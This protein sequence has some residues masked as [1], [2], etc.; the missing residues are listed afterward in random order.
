MTRVF[1][2]LATLR[3]QLLA[4]LMTVV[5]V[6]AYEILP[7]RKL[8]FAPD[9]VFERILASDG[10]IGGNSR[11]IWVNKDKDHL[12]CNLQPGYVY[13]YCG[14]HFAFDTLAHSGID[15][16]PYTQLNTH[17][18]YEGK[19]KELRVYLRNRDPSSPKDDIQKAKYISVNMKS[20]EFNRPLTIGLHEFF[21]AEWWKDQ[22]NVPREKAQLAFDNVVTLGIEIFSPAP[23]GDHQ[24]AI[25]K[26]IFSG[27]LVPRSLWYFCLLAVWL[28]V[29][30]IYLLY[31][32]LKLSKRSRI[33]VRVVEELNR[34]NQTLA[35][36]KE[37][38]RMLSTNDALT[39][40]KN[41]HGVYTSY[42]E[43]VQSLGDSAKMSII[44][45]DVDHFK[46][47]NDRR[48]HTMG[49]E[50]LTQFSDIL[51]SNTR[52]RDIVGRWGGEEFIIICA[53]A[54]IDQAKSLAE[55]I[56]Q[57]VS[58]TAMGDH[59][60]IM[61]TISCGVSEIKE[62]EEFDHAVTRADD[63]LYEAKHAGRNCTVIER[64]DTPPKE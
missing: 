55:K 51:R 20:S 39:G 9:S 23:F 36:E 46:R 4:V 52:E 13:P 19:A 22:Q 33:T 61:I 35:N 17:I 11:A 48:G 58:I 14:M 41:R 47:I 59:K 6:L 44:L 16:S 21:V 64:N 27:P 50:V 42:N 12:K 26:F 57:L 5:F 45:I 7:K 3:L 62:G 1:T 53:H 28:L 63:C 10:D 49:D 37:K 30:F 32:L 54:G 24:I 25:E 18:Q 15:L 38:F 8:E 2:T 60:P 43:L 34:Q 40:I 29:S 56:R 31:R